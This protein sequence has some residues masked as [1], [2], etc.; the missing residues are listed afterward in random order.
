MRRIP[1]ALVILVPAAAVAL[2]LF[3]GAPVDWQAALAAPDSRAHAMIFGARLPQILLALVVG[4]GLA[5]TGS[6]C[7][8]L[9]RNPLAEPFVLGVSGGAAF[10][11]TA[12]LAAT[13]LVPPLA[14]TASVG[15]AAIGAALGG[16]L[17]T[18]IVWIVAARA[19]I[20]IGDRRTEARAHGTSMILA[21]IVINA[22]AAGAITF[23]KVVVRASTTQRVLHWLAGFL[24]PP[25]PA[26]L[27]IVA[28]FVVVGSAVLILEAPRLNLVALG[29]EQAAHLG[30]DV[31]A[32]ERRVF[33]ASSVVVGAIVSLT[34]MIGFVGLLVPHFVRRLF[35]ADHRVVL[36][37]S[38]AFGG[39]MLV[40]CELLVRL[41]VEVF[42]QDFPVGALT[43]LLGGPLFLALLARRAD[44]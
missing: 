33:L 30:V 12:T 38:F 24:Y 2:A 1:I 5:I 4:S 43:A 42:E 9:L 8:G 16:A 41:I 34:G 36:P 20:E 3:G 44:R 14:R 21:G 22:I 26:E 19:S 31:A 39:A 35:G 27:A 13:S 23:L 11:A 18:L 17:A 29:E 28:G 7:Q 10:G 6:A 15:L 25:P 32:L 40:L 37:V